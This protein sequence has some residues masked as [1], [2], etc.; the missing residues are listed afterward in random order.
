LPIDFLS[1]LM[2]IRYMKKIDP[3]NLKVMSLDELDKIGDEALLNISKLLQRN[4]TKKS[5]EKIF[6]VNKETLMFI[7]EELKRRGFDLE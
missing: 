5:D 4:K 3:E 1:T 7:H 6:Q 2:Y